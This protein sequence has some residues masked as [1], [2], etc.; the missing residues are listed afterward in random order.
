[1]RV[2][3]TSKGKIAILAEND[4]QDQELWVPLYRL[5]EARASK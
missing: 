2:G 3:A 1:M 5:R 4:Y